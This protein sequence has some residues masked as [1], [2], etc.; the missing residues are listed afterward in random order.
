MTSLNAAITE[1]FES[2]RIYNP[3]MQP[4][5]CSPWLESS[6]RKRAKKDNLKIS[7]SRKWISC[8]Q[9]MIYTPTSTRQNFDFRKKFYYIFLHHEVWNDGF[10]MAFQY[11][12][13]HR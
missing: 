7:V 10:K 1:D 13:W 4:L 3:G 11:L 8:V 5:D 12:V 9:D 6:L 2:K